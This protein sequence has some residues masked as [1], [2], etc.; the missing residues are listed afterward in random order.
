MIGDK[1]LATALINCSGTKY[2]TL[3]KDLANAF[4]LGDDKYPSGLTIALGILNAY[5]QCLRW[6]SE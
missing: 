4:A 6:T 3:R 1:V 5:V 2:A